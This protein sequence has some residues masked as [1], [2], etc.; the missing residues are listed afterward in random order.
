MPTLKQCWKALVF[1]NHT[2][3]YYVVLRAWCA[4][5]FGATDL[6]LRILGLVIGVL[7]VS[8]I[9]VSCWLLN[10]SAPLLPL[11]LFALNK[12][13]LRADSL[14]PYGLA[15][16]WL[17][18]A[19]AF[20]WQ[21]TFQ[22]QRGRTIILATICAVLSVQTLFM[23]AFLLGAICAASIAVLA[24][25]RAWRGVALI[26]GIGLTAAFSLLPYLPIIREANKSLGV[27]AV[28]NSVGY[29]TRFFV[30]TLTTNNLIAGG[31][32]LVLLAGGLA[33]LVVPP[34]RRPL[35][36]PVERTG[37]PFLFTAVASAA[38]TIATGG[39]LWWIEFP[40]QNRYYL[41]LV[42]VLALS[43]AVVTA[44]FRKWTM[45]RWGMLV[46]SVLLATAFF[47]PAYNYTAIRLTN[48]DLSATAVA[49]QAEPDDVIVLTRFAY[50][51]TFQR[52]YHGPA[53][54]HTIP[55]I[56]D[57]GRFRWDL[58]KEAMMEPDPIHELL[59]RIE[60]ALRS[61]H[62]VFLVGQVG[63]IPVMQPEPLAPAPLTAHGWDMESYIR[64]WRERVTY[65][66]EQHAVRG[67]GIPLPEQERVDPLER[68]T[69]QV[70]SG[71]Q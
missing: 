60:F 18:L 27:R 66:L 13:T 19:F 38:A 9:W 7:L 40:V 56:S 3:L 46:A 52:Y 26:F 10:K 64:N 43:G 35:A 37:E 34:L 6:G 55:D 44:A 57:Y 24:V 25:R 30:W 59:V 36:D 29:I 63:P 51:I 33:L 70:I 48:C 2:V 28:A 39:F 23:N 62:S 31:V 68:L 14:R 54:W 8:A 16:V 71:R 53:P 22:P 21:L 41:P 58:V 5:G 4:L 1:D 45:L 42:A 69:V 67:R 12:F 32:W 20:I 49:A 15:L 11:T 50:G 65:L 17:V 47:R 61:G